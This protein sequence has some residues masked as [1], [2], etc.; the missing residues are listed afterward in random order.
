MKKFL[1]ALSFF[2]RI[3]INIKSEVSKD[4]FYS[5][6]SLL[7]IVGLVIGAILYG[8]WY[9]LG[10]IN[11]EVSALL[12]IF[13][14]IWLTGGLHMDGFIDT[15]DGVLSNR[16]RERIFE[17]M[18]DSRIG[19]FG[20]IGILMLIL[21]YFIMFKYTDG[22]VLFFMPIVARSCAL[23]AA[24]LSKYA[25]K[26]NDMGKGFV[27][28][29]GKKEMIFALIFATVIIGVVNYIYLLSFSICILISIYFVHYFKKKLSGM[30]GDTIGMLIELNQILFLFSSY[31]LSL[32]LGGNP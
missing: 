31:I 27:E 5:S 2:T 25:K 19:A 20:A 13:V 22:L 4:E 24:S 28:G 10:D 32:Y 6:M 18:K 11:N 9:V 23:M 17:I 16:D 14:Y 29:M 26:T 8:V 30:T 15:I 1:V 3:P 7:P 21:G 12:L